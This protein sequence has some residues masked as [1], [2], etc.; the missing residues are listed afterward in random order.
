MIWAAALLA[1]LLFL[2]KVWSDQAAY[3]RS[4]RSERLSFESYL[5]RW[6]REHS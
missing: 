2:G 5:E 4:I 1:L 3:E 6:E